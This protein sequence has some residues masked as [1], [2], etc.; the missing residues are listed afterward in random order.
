M[1]KA[2][3]GSGFHGPEMD[4]LCRSRI[5]RDGGW[6]AKFRNPLVVGFSEVK[7]KKVSL[8]RIG[9]TQREGF[10]NHGVHWLIAGLRAAEFVGS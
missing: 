2:R 7:I 6:V 10:S 8:D 3:L 9:A 4:L 1:A 5:K